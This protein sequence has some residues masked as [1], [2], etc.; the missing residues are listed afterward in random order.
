LVVVV[1]DRFPTWTVVLAILLVLVAIAVLVFIITGGRGTVLVVIPGF[2]LE[3]IIIGLVLG[4]F[5]VVIRRTHTH[6]AQELPVT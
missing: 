3:S 4:F 1:R 2:P 6:K 5:W